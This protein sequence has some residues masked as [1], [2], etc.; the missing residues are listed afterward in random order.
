MLNDTRKM[1]P[2]LSNLWE[3]QDKQLISSTN[4]KGGKKA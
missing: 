3:I 1:Q 2:T 4:Y